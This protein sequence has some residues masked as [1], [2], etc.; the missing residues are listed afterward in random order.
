M[1]TEEK[2]NK[3]YELKSMR[4]KLEV[5]REEE[6][7]AV[8]TPE[9]QEKVDRIFD[10]WDDTIENVKSQ[11]AGLREEIE[12]EVLSCGKTVKGARLMAVW[13]K[14]WVSW[15]EKKLDG[16]RALIPQLNEARKVGEP[17]V[18]IREVK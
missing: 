7:K 11:M 16:M 9:L 17:T 4:D 1:N 6:V 14:G 18:T 5:Q 2:L 15:D 10:K 12:S 13:N 3:L 8:L